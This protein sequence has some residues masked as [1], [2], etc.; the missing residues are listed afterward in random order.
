MGAQPGRE[1]RSP[2]GTGLG[3]LACMF[4]SWG[5]SPLAGVGAGDIHLMGL[6]F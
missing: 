2:G 5:W 1:E 3:L 6:I 4:E